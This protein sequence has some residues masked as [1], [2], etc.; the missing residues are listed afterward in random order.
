[1]YSK[2]ENEVDI[3][4]ADRFTNNIVNFAGIMCI[5]LILWVVLYPYPIVKLVASGFEGE[6]LMLAVDFTRIS[7]FG[8]FFTCIIYILSA[9]LQLKN[10]FIIPAAMGVVLNSIIIVS[11]V[12]SAKVNNV[13]I[14]SL[15]TVI[16]MMFQMLFLLP[17]VIKNGYRYKFVLEKNDRYLKQM[18]YLSIPVILGISGNQ[19]NTIIDRT[20]ASQIAIGGISALTYA[21]RL[22][23][24]IQG[25]F[26]MSL[27]TVMYPEIA[28]LAASNDMDR[29]KRLL[30]ESIGVINIFVVP[31]T[32]GAMIFS[33]P[34]IRMLFSRGAFDSEAIKLTSSALF[35]YSIGMVSY[36]LREVLSRVF[37]SMQDTKTPMLNASL[38]ILLNIVLIIILSKY[39]GI[40]GLA[41]S[42]SI[43]A[44]LTTILLFFS[45]KKKIG[46]FGT[47][48]I[49]ITFFKISIASATMGILAKVLF[50]YLSTILSQ[51]NSLIIAISLGAIIYFIIIYFMKIEDVDLIVNIIKRRF[52]KDKV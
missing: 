30:A 48:Q 39:L 28:K 38:G 12:I 9:Y 34:I 17:A 14:L 45:L 4:S 32:A 37:Y 15:G 31:A 44:I 29:L 11:I 22:N 40:G 19:I 36:G 24:F 16:G 23:L 5:I 2:I 33:E 46:E 13:F 43:A 47:K 50:D 27:S 10:C 51:N 7:I 18:L 3:K 42:T 35:F 49:L 41:L 6:I 52:S 20:I 25:I 1:M 21:N 26:V 8:I